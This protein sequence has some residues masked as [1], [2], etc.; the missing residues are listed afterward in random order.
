MNYLV[1]MLEIVLSCA[2]KNK[3][4]TLPHSFYNNKLYRFKYLGV[5][6]LKTIF[7]AFFFTLES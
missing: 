7:S 1:N 5:I 2:E 4:E 3:F 6:R